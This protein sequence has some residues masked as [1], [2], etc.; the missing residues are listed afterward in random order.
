MA[1]FYLL[2]R[3]HSLE[4]VKAPG[5]YQPAKEE[6][7]DGDEQGA[8]AEGQTAQEMSSC[9]GLCSKRGRRDRW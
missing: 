9:H 5:S 7:S 8:K 2:R 3:T 4:G 1:F 6:L